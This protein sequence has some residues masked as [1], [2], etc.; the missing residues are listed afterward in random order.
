MRVRRASAKSDAMKVLIAE[1][2]TVSRLLLESML[3]EWGY[4]VVSTGDGLEAW[5]VLL[6][7]EAPKLAA[8]PL[9]PHS[10]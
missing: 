2:E 9:L 3:Q 6:Q 8:A 5:D 10:M 1:D 7:P 4:D